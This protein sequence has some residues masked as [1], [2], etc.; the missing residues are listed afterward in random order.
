MG[1]EQHFLLN[2]DK[3][4]YMSIR[5]IIKTLGALGERAV[6]A[7]KA[8]HYDESGFVRLGFAPADVQDQAA[9]LF[10][11]LGI[12]ERPVSKPWAKLVTD[13]NPHLKRPQ[14]RILMQMLAT[15]SAQFDEAGI[16]GI[17]RNQDYLEILL[18]GVSA[19]ALSFETALRHFLIAPDGAHQ[20]VVSPGGK[21]LVS[22]RILGADS[23]LQQADV[24]IFT[25]A[26]VALKDLNFVST[27]LKGL[28]RVDALTGISFLFAGTEPEFD[29][30]Q[31]GAEEM[32]VPLMDGIE[33]E[34][35]LLADAGGDRVIPLET[36][37]AAGA[38]PLSTSINFYLIPTGLPNLTRM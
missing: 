28:E 3:Y 19:K 17:R 21:T 13:L 30:F 35:V 6:E 12:P 16:P 5:Q 20:G 38:I 14:A 34:T 27:S 4:L 22:Q 8:F 25:E 23:E 15:Q 26:G 24:S 36:Q 18:S 2:V 7:V 31:A 10:L 11:R 29:A 37:D 32:I 33:G 9:E 1:D